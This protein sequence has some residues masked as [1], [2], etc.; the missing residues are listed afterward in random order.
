MVAVEAAARLQRL[1]RSWLSGA[2]ADQDPMQ[3]HILRADF[4]VYPSLLD[5][6]ARVVRQEQTQEALGAHHPSERS[7][8]VL[9][10]AAASPGMR[11]HRRETHLLRRQE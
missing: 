10:E 1:L 7:L 5:L 8:A 9:A 6:E 2:G 11:Q 3:V 4:L